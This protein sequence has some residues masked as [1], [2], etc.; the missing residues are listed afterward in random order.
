MFPVS[1]PYKEHARVKHVSTCAYAEKRQKSLQQF[2]G[3][4]M[5]EENNI[6]EL[7]T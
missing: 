2:S 1:F 3:A 5:R 6:K 7:K 4:Q